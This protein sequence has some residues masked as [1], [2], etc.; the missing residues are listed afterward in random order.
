MT[1]ILS[2]SIV[3]QAEPRRVFSVIARPE[4]WPALF[5]PCL[6]VEIIERDHGVE[7]IAV[8]AMVNGEPRSWQSRRTVDEVCLRIDV[9]MI[10]PLV[11][12]A[13]MR[14]RWRVYDLGQGQSLLVLEHDCDLVDTIGGLVAGVETP[15]QA[16]DWISSGIDSNS[17]VELENIRQAAEG[18]AAATPDADNLYRASHSVICE[19]PPTL[20]FPFVADP[21]RW[22]GLFKACT[23]VEVLS[24]DGAWDVVKI[25]ADQAGRNVDW[26]TRRRVNAEALVVDYELIDPMPYTKAMSGRWRVV[27]LGPE[28]CLLAVERSWSIIDPVPALREEIATVAAAAAFVAGF[29]ETNARREMEAIATI[30]ADHTAAPLYIET[31]VYVDVDADAIYHTLANAGA[32]P[33]FA[34]HCRSLHVGFDDGVYQE[35][36]FEIE[37]AAGE[38]EVFRSFRNCNRVKRSISFVQ[39]EPPRALERHHGRWQVAATPAGAR[40]ICRHFATPRR[41]EVADIIAAERRDEA[42]R[43]A[44]EANSRAIVLACEAHIKAGGR[45]RAA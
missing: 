4:D 37:T 21:T 11:L 3:C 32:W 15:A 35:L 23:A 26:T 43:K 40:V 27:A 39:V 25:H 17:I 12:V 42:L 44:I 16:K 19:A 28:R 18:L 13:A 22:P 45:E 14:T 20:I 29:V 38:R 1:I 33:T 30:A 7:R 5:E 9:E 24:P 36:L 2:H 31:E 6:A 34:P 10:A 8:T 41:G